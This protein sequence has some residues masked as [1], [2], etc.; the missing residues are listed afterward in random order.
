[1][2]VTAAVPVGPPQP[3]VYNQAPGAHDNEPVTHRHRFVVLAVQLSDGKVLWERTVTEAL[4]HEGGHYTGSLASASPITDGERVYAFFGSYGLYALDLAGNLLWKR[5]FGRMA[6]RHAHGEGSSPALADGILVVNWDHEEQSKIIG[7]DA[8]TGKERWRV[9]R[10]ENTSWSTP[11]IVPHEGRFQVIVSA[12]KRVRSYDLQ[13][14]ELIW[15]CGGL[16]RN[17]VASPVAHQG[18]VVVGNSYDKQAMMAI[19]LKGAKGDLTGTDQILWSTKRMTP[20]VPSPVIAN[21]R[22]YFLRHNQNVLSVLNPYT[23]DTLQGPFRLEGVR[24]IFA[25]PV[26]ADGRLYITGRGGTTLVLKLGDAPEA[27][28]LNRLDDRFSASA[29]I[30]DQSLILRGEKF[31]YCLSAP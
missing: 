17:V 7:L 22:L 5:E 18:V 25:S 8:K 24:E 4:P 19:R 20:Y 28:A 26:A 15:E 1:M 10:D 3:P 2:F 29:A 31:L 13:T 14:G 21:G 27:L 12:T 6:T 9:E 23:G 30:K 16:A 11:L